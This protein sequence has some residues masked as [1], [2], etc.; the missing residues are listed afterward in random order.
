M[1]N[2]KTTTFLPSVLVTGIHNQR[3]GLEGVVGAY[4]RIDMERVQFIVITHVVN[5]VAV[6]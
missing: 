1:V 3:V 4:E 2:K 5:V 6:G